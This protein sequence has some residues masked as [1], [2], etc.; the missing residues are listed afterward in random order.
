MSVA[1]ELKLKRTELSERLEE[2]SRLQ[3]ELQEQIRAVDAVIT[4]YEPGYVA[5]GSAG[6]RRNRSPRKD[7]SVRDEVHREPDGRQD[8][9]EAQ[10]A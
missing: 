5:A 10:L 2:L 4:I 8:R 9:F 1:Q 6:Q 3:S 7:D